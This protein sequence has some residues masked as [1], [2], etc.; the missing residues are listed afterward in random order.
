[1]IDFER[2][3]IRPFADIWNT[4]PP[5]PMR[6]TKESWDKRADRWAEN[7]KDMGSFKSSSDARIAE[8]VKFLQDHG[9]L[10]PE[11]DVVDLGCGPGQFA[12]AFA[13]HVHH[14]TGVDLSDSMVKHAAEFAAEAGLDNVDFRSLNF[15]EADIDALGWRERF[16]LVFASITPAVSTL[17]D[18]QNMMA[19]SRGWC[20]YG[21]F[22]SRVHEVEYRAAHELYNMEPPMMKKDGKSTYGLFNMLWLS[23]YNPFVHFYYDGYEETRPADREHAHQ[24][25]DRLGLHDDPDRE[26]D[27]ILRF[28][29]S[30]ADEDGIVHSEYRQSY[31]WLLWDMKKVR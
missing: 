24:L 7:L 18:V 9:Q 1:M 31:V 8:A 23:G 16:D 3:D 2:E 21:G 26:A 10:T 25:A 5:S 14:V 15:N 13:P 12:M 4:R 17:K 6:Q 29:E 11:Q 19:M 22:R 27:K 28:L 20:Y 30:I